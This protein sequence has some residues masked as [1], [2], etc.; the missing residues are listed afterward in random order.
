MEDRLINL[1]SK[2]AFAE[3]LLEELNHTVFRQQEQIDHLQQQL[4][5]L[6]QQMQTGAPEEKGD[7]RENIP[8]HY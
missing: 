2:L 5:L 3:H 7:A 1:E 8:P 6:Y 4:R